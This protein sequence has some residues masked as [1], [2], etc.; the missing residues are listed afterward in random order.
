MT[1]GLFVK[2]NKEVEAVKMIQGNYQLE[3]AVT[4]FLGP[5][6]EFVD[7]GNMLFGVF[8]DGVYRA[9]DMEGREWIVEDL[10]D[11]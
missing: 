10:S 9:K 3:E 7:Y 11:E 5:N 6:S 2:E 4:Q 1:Y 8:E